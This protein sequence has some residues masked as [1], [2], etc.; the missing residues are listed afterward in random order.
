LDHLLAQFSVFRN[1][2][3]NAIAIGLRPIWGLTPLMRPAGVAFG[4]LF[5][6]LPLCCDPNAT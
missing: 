5:V 2:A 4:D 6:C 1:V 3:L